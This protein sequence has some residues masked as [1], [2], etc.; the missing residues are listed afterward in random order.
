MAIT[1]AHPTSTTRLSSG[2]DPGLVFDIGMYRGEDTAFYLSRGYRVVGAEANADL[3][4]VLHRRFRAEV[5]SGRVTI[6]PVAIGPV[7]ARARFAVSAGRQQFS[8]A[9][10]A[11]VAAARRHG[12]DFASVEVDMITIA[13]VIDEYGIPYFMKVDIEGMDRAVVE[14]MADL[15]TVPPLLSMESAATSPS[16]TLD[17]VLGEVAL[18]RRLGYRRFKLVDQR[19]V[20]GLAGRALRTEGL[21][22]IYDHEDEASGPFGDEAPGRWHPAATIIPRMLYRMAR[23]DV[24]SVR[25]RLAGTV[26]GARITG[27]ARRTVKRIAPHVHAH[28]W[29]DLHASR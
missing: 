5:R 14:S 12:V 17:T 1:M 25:G 11:F 18:L 10:P 22:V 26:W 27:P 21:P 24:L 28:R 8:T 16:A 2:H 13:D 20:S 3:V 7:R 15:P 23:H 6:L 29:Y 9:D 4:E 19:R